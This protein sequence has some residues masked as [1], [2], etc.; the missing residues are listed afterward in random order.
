[1]LPSLP[2][3]GEYRSRCIQ[4]LLVFLLLIRSICNKSCSRSDHCLWRL[5]KKLNNILHRLPTLVSNQMPPVGDDR[6]FGTFGWKVLGQ[7]T[8]P[9]SIFS[10]QLPSWAPPNWVWMHS[11]TTKLILAVLLMFC[12]IVFEMIFFSRT[13]MFHLWGFGEVKVEAKL[14]RFNK[15]SFLFSLQSRTN[16]KIGFWS[17]DPVYNIHSLGEVELRKSLI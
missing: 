4:L 7:I 3:W 13:Y 10:T 9:I 5:S 14:S 2:T 16:F 12:K 6:A 8:I 15:S 17:E 1:M 11:N